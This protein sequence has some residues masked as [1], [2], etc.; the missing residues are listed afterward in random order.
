MVIYVSQKI[1]DFC[2]KELEK[3]NPVAQSILVRFPLAKH[4]IISKYENYQNKTTITFDKAVIHS[5]IDKAVMEEWIKW[6]KG[7]NIKPFSFE[8]YI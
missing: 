8:I 6:D 1:I 5:D 7:L 4:V 2:K 3:P